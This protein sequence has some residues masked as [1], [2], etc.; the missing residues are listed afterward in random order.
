MFYKG[1]VIKELCIT[2]M[3]ILLGDR[4]LACILDIDL[5]IGNSMTS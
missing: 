2:E 3:V 4:Q 1:L 5:W